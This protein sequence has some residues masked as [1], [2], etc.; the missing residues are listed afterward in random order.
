M[1]LQMNVSPVC[2]SLVRC[3]AEKFCWPRFNVEVKDDEMV[4]K[5]GTTNKKETQSNQDNTR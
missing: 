5:G 1:C 2:T 3:V 4:K